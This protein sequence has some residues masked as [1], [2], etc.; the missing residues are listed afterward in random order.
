MVLRP[1]GAHTLK[2]RR[3]A[4]GLIAEGRR[5]II[6]GTMTDHQTITEPSAP[7][8]PVWL[9]VEQAAARAQISLRTVY[10]EVNAGR[11]RAARVGGRRAIRIKPE[12][13]DEYMERCATPV[14][15]AR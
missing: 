12:W 7:A 15:Q 2:R 14:E 6:E 8:Q 11:L 3:P 4:A 13:I 5:Q 10:Y 1:R 9:T